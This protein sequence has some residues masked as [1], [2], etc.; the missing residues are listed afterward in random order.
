MFTFLISLTIAVNAMDLRAERRRYYKRTLNPF[1]IVAV[2]Q[3]LVWNAKHA[4]EEGD[5]VEGR[6]QAP[7]AHQHESSHKPP[8]QFCI[9]SVTINTWRKPRDKVLQ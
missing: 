4:E 3:Q 8:A 6:Q 9:Q 2:P 5:H 7:V 1:A